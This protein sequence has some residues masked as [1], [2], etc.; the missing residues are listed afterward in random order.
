MIV[1]R[2][3]EPVEFSA[4]LENRIVNLV[5]VSDIT[6]VPQWVDDSTQ[7][8]GIYPDSLRVKLRDD[9]ALHGAQ[10][11]L[12]LGETLFDMSPGAARS[13]AAQTAALPHDGMEPM[14]RMVKW[15]I[16]QSVQ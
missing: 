16:D 12:P 15:V 8:I 7:T 10:R 3:E 13:I 6:R 1:S 2:T 14:R 4:R 5:P 11:T 9:L